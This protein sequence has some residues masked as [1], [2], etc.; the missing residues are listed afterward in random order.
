MGILGKMK[1]RRLASGGLFSGTPIDEQ[2][3]GGSLP[4]AGSGGS[5]TRTYTPLAKNEDYYTY[6]SGPEHQFFTGDI[7]APAL[8]PGSGSGLPDVHIPEQNTGTNWANVIQGIPTLGKEAALAGNVL[9][10]FGIDNA[11]TQGL[12]KYGNMAGNPLKTVADLY[13]GWTGT[14][15]GGLA[16]AAAPVSGEGALA[17]LGSL[18]TGAMFGTSG[19]GALGATGAT[20][21]LGD[22]ATATPGALFG[23]SGSAAA[24]AGAGSLGG[25]SLGA[26]TGGALEGAGAGAGAGAGSAAGAEGAAAGTAGS[27][28]LGAL[29]TAGLGA[30]YAAA[31]IAAG[32]LIHKAFNAHGSIDRNRAA[33]DQVMQDWGPPEQIARVGAKGMFPVQ[34]YNIPGIG[35]TMLTQQQLDQLSGNWYGA[36]YHPDGDQ[37]GWQKKL[38]DTLADFKQN[39]SVTPEN[40]QRLRDKTGGA[41]N[42]D[43]I[44]KYLGGHAHGGAIHGHLG[45]TLVDRF[46]SGGDQYV[47]GPGTGRSDDID[48]KLSNGEYVMDAET[49]AMLGDGSS[50][51]GARKLDQLRHNLR[52]HKGRALAK[53]KFSP[54]AK[55]PASYLEDK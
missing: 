22:L 29:G 54:N 10:G 28:S 47:Q 19:A 53:G 17:G 3:P 31:V 42:Q 11:F 26:T 21:G 16:G 18:G 41:W 38:Q 1:K 2:L 52:K 36:V 51:A 35:P 13:K 33:F 12:T 44:D 45:T 23:T 48:A 55:E 49:V 46:R 20:A 34:V 24:G 8:A 14:G 15:T 27:G 40:V 43:V 7:R 50:D 4:P 9:Q 37:E 5:N 39:Y 32:Q 30:A 6:G 25:A